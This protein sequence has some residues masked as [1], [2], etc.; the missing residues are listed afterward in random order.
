MGVFETILG[1]KL[2]NSKVN[3]ENAKGVDFSNIEEPKAFKSASRE[4]N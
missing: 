4:R 1:K 3:N 2:D